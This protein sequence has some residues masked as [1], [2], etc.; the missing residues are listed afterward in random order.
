MDET[1]SHGIQ[2]LKEAEA[3]VSQLSGLKTEVLDCDFKFVHDK[4]DDT[5]GIKFIITVVFLEENENG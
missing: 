5:V 3:Y 2:M 4:N 1:R